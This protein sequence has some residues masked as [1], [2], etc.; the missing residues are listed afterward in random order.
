MTTISFPH[1]YIQG[2]GPI[3]TILLLAGTL[4]IGAIIGFFGFSFPVVLLAGVIIAPIL[5]MI[6]TD[7]LLAIAIIFAFF[8]AGIVRY[9]ASTNSIANLAPALLILLIFKA[10]FEHGNIPRV[11][12]VQLKDGVPYGQ[13]LYAYAFFLIIVIASAFGHSVIGLALIFALKIYLP[14]A[15]VLIMAVVSQSFQQSMFKLW[16][17]LLA[18]AAV[19]VPF[20][21]YQHFFVAS[22]RSS[23]A[24]G[25]TWDSVVGTMGGNPDGGGSSGALAIFLALCL[26]YLINLV[27]LRLLRISFAAILGLLI[28]AGIALAEVKIVFVLLPLGMIAIFWSELRREPVKAFLIL[29]FGIFSTLAVLL[30]YQ[31]VFWQ[32]SQLLGSDISY[33][34]SRSLE[35]MLDPD[36]FHATTGEVGRLAGLL[37]WW[38]D[39]WNDPV[40]AIFGHGPGASRL[41]NLFIGDIARHYFPFSVDSTALAALLWDFGIAGAA[42][43]FTMFIAGIRLGMRRLKNVTS[44]RDAAC[45]HTAMI[46]IVFLAFS[47]IYNK[48]ILYLPQ[49]SLL[50]GLCLATVLM[51]GNLAPSIPGK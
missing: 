31:Y 10:I 7:A 23:Q 18:I 8:I 37:L 5:L 28:F 1:K 36:Y 30:I 48:D 19:Q 11:R 15:G 14:L 34:L 2:F 39:A 4:L 3:G 13:V 24:G 33:N 25:P 26:I 38:K 16:N 43:Y 29:S 12:C 9:F 42:I 46:G 35:Y 6:R 50:L 49:M 41:N 44:E 47:A 22:A 17:L 27:R 32:S 45:V 21:V 51:R 40:T 20:V